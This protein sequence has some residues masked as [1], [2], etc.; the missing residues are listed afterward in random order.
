M[1]IGIIYLQY[2]T[3]PAAFWN[4]SI[5]ILIAIFPFFNRKFVMG[6]ACISE[7][8]SSASGI[9]FD[10]NQFG[11]FGKLKNFVF[12]KDKY[13]STGKYQIIDSDYRSSIMV[14]TVMQLANQLSGEWDKK[15]QK[16]FSLEDYQLGHIKYSI[17]EKNE[18]GISVI[19][20]NA[21]MYHF[22]NNAFLKGKIKREEGY[23]IFLAKNDQLI[24][25][26]KVNEKIADEKVELVNQ[27]DYF[28]NTILFV[29]GQKEDL[30]RDYS[31]VFDRIYSEIN[32]KRQLELL[33]DLERK[34]PT[35]MICGINPGKTGNSINFF[36]NSSIDATIN[37]KIISATSD[38]VL[39]VPELINASKKMH[40][41]LKYALFSSIL[42]QAIILL[43][44]LLFVQNKLVILGILLISSLVI[45]FFA[46]F[47]KRKLSYLPDQPAILAQSHQAA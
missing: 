14:I 11:I 33:K 29:P 27:L 35:G 3:T 30:G 24:G 28:G 22:G 12:A 10:F 17:V 6:F 7:K 8:L 19:D 39:F 47:F 45:E 34:E 32:E 42:I 25:K 1:S 4:Y 20:D 16:L 23:N 36:I 46:K 15:Y 41:F 38:N 26:F 44:S 5:S 21:I 18:N 40:T 37:E 31:I 2:K 9:S 43:L 13:I